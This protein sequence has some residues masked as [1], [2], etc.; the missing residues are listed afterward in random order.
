MKKEQGHIDICLGLQW[1]DEGKGKIVDYLARKYDIVARFQGGPNAGHTLYYNGKK[2]VLHNLP[3]GIL[4]DHVKNLIGPGC[5]VNPTTLLEEIKNAA[6]ILGLSPSDIKQ[7]VFVSKHAFII[8]PYHQYLD[9]AIEKAKG[10]ASV[11]TTGK[12]IGPVYSDIK[13]RIAIRF[14][15]VCSDSTPPSRAF[16]KFE[17][18]VLEELEFYVKKYQYSLVGN[19]ERLDELK[20]FYA[21]LDELKNWVTFIDT[22]WL[23]DQLDA[24]KNVLAEGAQGTMLDNN[25]GCYPMVTSSNTVAGAAP[26][27]LG[28]PMKYFR[29]TI[30]V[31]KWYTTKVGEGEFPSEIDDEKIHKALQDAG[32]ERGATTGRPRRCGW[33]DIPQLLYALRINGV[34]ELIITK[35]DI[36]PLKN[37]EIVTHYEINGKPTTEFPFNLDD[38][39]A[40]RSYVTN[41]AWKKEEGKSLLDND[42]RIYFNFV[43]GQMDGEMG[44]PNVRITH[45]STGPGRDDIEEVGKSLFI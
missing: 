21:S 20:Q 13:D 28:V 33:L 44:K 22:F 26:V 17:S 41:L 18:Q 4:H 8:H 6:E 2:I 25:F 37:V 27:G 36:N 7:R 42:F 45:I 9:K 14:G 24:G 3:S 16:A 39:E 12:G 31:I 5:V 32:Q 38:I 15:D 35:V 19:H 1:G 23:Q 40:T 30:G 10:G 43:R 11:G 29:K 34:N